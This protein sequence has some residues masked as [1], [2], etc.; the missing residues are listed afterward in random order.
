MEIPLFFS[1]DFGKKETK[2]WEIH[3]SSIALTGDFD[4]LLL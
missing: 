4:D 3:N 1:V 2:D